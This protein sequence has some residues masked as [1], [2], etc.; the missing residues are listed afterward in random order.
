MYSN[1]SIMLCN[2]YLIF[3]KVLS[4]KG[5][6]SNL[7]HI[8]ITLLNAFTFSGNLANETSS[9]YKLI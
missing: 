5:R 4:D 9:L 8:I 7:T 3:L 6:V 2:P 1:F